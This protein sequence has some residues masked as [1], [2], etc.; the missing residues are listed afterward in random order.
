MTYDQW[1]TESGYAER[2]PEPESFRRRPP[3][4]E[5]LDIPR[6]TSSAGSAETVLNHGNPSSSRRE[7]PYCG[8][9]EGL[10]IKSDGAG[11]DTPEYTCEGCFTASD[12]GPSFDDLPAA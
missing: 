5:P 2:D 7:C 3:C 11:F 4:G 6:T 10:R 9:T 1:K 12:E 8:A